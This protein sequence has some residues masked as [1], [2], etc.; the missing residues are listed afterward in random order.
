MEK[1]L[2]WII[3]DEWPDYSVE[4]AALKA[5]YPD[6]DIRYSGIPFQ[7]DLEDFG[8][9]ADVVFAQVSADITADVIVND[10][11]NAAVIDKLYAMGVKLIALRS[12]GYNNVDVQAAKAAGIPVTNVNGYCT[13]DIA[14]YVLAAMF[15]FYKPIEALYGQLKNGAWGVT[16]LSQPVHRLSRQTLLLMGFGYIGKV[17]AQRAHALG[18]T[19]LAYDPFVTDE[20][21]REFG[22]EKVAM[23]DDLNTADAIS[24]HV[25]YS[26]ETH[27]IVDAHRIAQMKPSAVLINVA[28]G[29]LVN[30]A[31]LIEAVKTGVIR[32]AVLD[33]VCHEPIA[34]DDPLLSVPG[35]LI[36]PHVS[37]ASEESVLDLRRRAVENALA[38]YRGERPLDLIPV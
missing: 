20:A 38:M 8:A 2:F 22:A 5:A 29:P 30:E 7:Q 23:D 31:D 19:V 33:V 24:V 6:C 15:H 21:A 11:V 9:Q 17:T 1:P 36:T 35:I 4:E 28:R 14:D 27:H 3:D 32:G 10:T 37:Y 25:P 18:M 26:K 34:M 16:A 12:A 13:E